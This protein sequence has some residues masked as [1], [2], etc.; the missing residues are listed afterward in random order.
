M[1]STEAEKTEEA[2]GTAELSLASQRLLDLRE[3]YGVSEA[4]CINEQ[5]ADTHIRG[6]RQRGTVL[7][8]HEIHTT[9]S[10]GAKSQFPFS[11]P[12]LNW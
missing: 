12:L 8:T 4:S 11:Y 9:G 5:N 7:M 6:I 10:H 1:S 3:E 2:V